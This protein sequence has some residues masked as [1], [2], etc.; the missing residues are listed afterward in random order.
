MRLPVGAGVSRWKTKKAVL[1]L[2]RA[3]LASQSGQCMNKMMKRVEKRLDKDIQRMIR[4]LKVAEVEQYITVNEYYLKEYIIIAACK[5]LGI[6][7]KLLH[8]HFHRLQIIENVYKLAQKE[9]LQFCLRYHPNEHKTIKNMEKDMLEKCG[10]LINSGGADQ[11]KKV[12]CESQC[13]ISGET[14]ALFLASAYGASCYCVATQG[15]R[16]DFG[17]HRGIEVVSVDEIDSINVWEKK[18]KPHFEYCL[19]YDYLFR[20]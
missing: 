17:Y 13:I 12:L 10:V 7:V 16:F 4:V 9:H 5:R 15:K 3:M 14:S 18:N 1:K 20:T 8:H 6:E 2:Y 11:L 19:D